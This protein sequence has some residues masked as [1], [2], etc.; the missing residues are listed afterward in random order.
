M[1]K[2]YKPINFKGWKFLDKE[3]ARK[4]RLERKKIRKL[5]KGM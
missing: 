5:Y 4:A 3:E 1:K 2:K